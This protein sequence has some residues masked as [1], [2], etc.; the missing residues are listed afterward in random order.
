[1]WG[2]NH[3]TGEGKTQSFL[4]ESDYQRG[5]NTVYL[6]WERV[7]KSGQNPKFFL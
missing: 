7:E 1:V 5:R 3:D 2:Q 4:V 6:R